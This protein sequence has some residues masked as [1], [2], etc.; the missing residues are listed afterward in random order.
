MI[1]FF[2]INFRVRLGNTMR[3]SISTHPVI[4]AVAISFLFHAVVSMRVGCGV[5]RCGASTYFYMIYLFMMFFEILYFF[6]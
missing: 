4:V 6:Y 5:V 2:R 3:D 1:Y